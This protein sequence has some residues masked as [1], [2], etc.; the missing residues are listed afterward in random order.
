MTAKLHYG[1]IAPSAFSSQ[2]TAT[3]GYDASNT[4]LS[5]IARPWVSTVAANGANDDWV[6]HDYGGTKTIAAVAINSCLQ[7]SGQILIG[8]GTPPATTYGTI[9]ATTVALAQNGVRK[10]SWSGAGSARY[11][12][13]DFTNA[14]TAR[15]AGVFATYGTDFMELGALYVFAN[16]MALPVDPLVDSDYKPRYPQNSTDLPNGQNIRVDRGAPFGTITLR[17]NARD[18]D[19]EQI[20]RIA[21]AGLCWLDLGIANAPELQWPVRF[22]DDTHTRPLAR[23]RREPVTLSFREVS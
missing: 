22:I 8:T 16:S 15:G 11:V 10:G 19:I 3:A 12:R 1:L 17:F 7:S 4:G 6:Q 2:L 21:R 13:A 23:P 14:A 5:A 20:A 18:T 9:D